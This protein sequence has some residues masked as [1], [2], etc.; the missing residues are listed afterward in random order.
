M[1]DNIKLDMFHSIARIV[2]QVD[3]YIPRDYKTI[4]GMWAVDTYKKDGVIFQLLDEGYTERIYVKDKLDVYKY[5]N[6]EIEFKKGDVD[7]IQQVLEKL[8][9]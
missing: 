4:G 1:G 7:D 2:H 3:N 6:D 5:Y 8:K 9:E